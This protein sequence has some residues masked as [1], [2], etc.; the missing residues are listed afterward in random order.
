MSMFLPKSLRPFPEP[1]HLLQ[2]CSTQIV[3]QLTLAMNGNVDMINAE[4]GAEIRIWF[5]IDEQEQLLD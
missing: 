5:S 3:H 4:P 1:T 2:R